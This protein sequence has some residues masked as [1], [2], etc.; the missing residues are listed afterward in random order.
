MY[1]VHIK[2]PAH[3]LTPNALRCSTL[4]AGGKRFGEKEKI[5]NPLSAC[6]EKVVGRSHD[7][8]SLRSRIQYASMNKNY[9][10]LSIYFEIQSTFT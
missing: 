7:R 2:Q 6:G 8:V 3:R 9:I 5:N 4:S 10:F 1:L